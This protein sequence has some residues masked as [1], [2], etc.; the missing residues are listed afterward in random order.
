MPGTTYIIHMKRRDVVRKLAKAGF[1][2]KEG[3]NHTRMAH[4][5]GR[6]T[7]IGRHAEIPIGTVRAIERQTGVKLRD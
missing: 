1:V 6:W 4:A 3:A 2:A 7:V 5:D